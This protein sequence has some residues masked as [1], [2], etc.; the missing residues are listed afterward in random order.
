MRSSS[1]LLDGFFLWAPVLTRLQSEPDQLT[2]VPQV[3]FSGVVE[4]ALLAAHGAHH[5]PL[6]LCSRFPVTSIPI[7]GTYYNTLVK[8]KHAGEI[9]YGNSGIPRFS[10]GLLSKRGGAPGSGHSPCGENCVQCEKT[11]YKW[12]QIRIT[13]NTPAAAVER[14]PHTA[15]P[16]P[17]Y[18]KR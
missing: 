14:F 13:V 17:I 11:V 9:D 8:S 16:K 10:T 2:D 7:Y 18:S 6:C 5:L 3:L 12:L 1:R 15:A 4:C